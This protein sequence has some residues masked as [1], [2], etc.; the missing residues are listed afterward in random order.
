MATII[1]LLFYT[2]FLSLI[3]QLI[4]LPFLLIYVKDKLLD[5]GWAFGRLITWLTVSLLIWFPANLGL[6]INTTYVVYV[7]LASL[8][9]MSINL[10]Y[11]H[12]D[13]LRSQLKLIK[14]HLLI[15]ELLFL[16]GFIFLALFRSVKADILD[17]EKFMDA[18]F[19]AS[20]LRAH[21]L[22]APDMWLAGKSINYYSFGH[23]MGSI[24]TRYWLQ[25]IEY[26]YNLLLAFIM[27]LTMT[28]AYSLVIN[29]ARLTK[30][31]SNQTGLI[32]GGIVGSILL[33][34]GG[35]THTI[36][37]F[38]SNLS[39][40]NYWYA[41]AT[42]FIDR[43]IHEFPAYSFVVSDIH[44]H[45]WDLPV[46]LLFIVVVYVWI[47]SLLS[48][49]HPKFPAS[50][51]WLDKLKIYLLPNKQLNYL[52]LAISMGVLLGV[53]LMTN[54]W[55]MAIYGLLIAIVGLVILI[56][57]PAQFFRL[58]LSALLVIIFLVLASSGWWMHFESIS[59]GVAKAYEHSPLWQLAVLWTGHVWLSLLALLT[60][61]GA[62]LGIRF[63]KTEQRANFYYMLAIVITAWIL[64]ILPELIYV[65][66][67][68]TGHPRANTMF[69]LTYQAFI[70]M[71]L[72]GAWVVATLTQFKNT[73]ILL[74]LPA[75]TSV[76]VI[77]CLLSL[78]S[79][80]G[81]RD[82]FGFHQ[83]TSLDGL[84]WFR[85]EAPNDYAALQWLR[86]YVSGQPT[87]LEAV[88]ESYTTFDRFSAFSGLPTV[89]GWRVHE[90]LW[91]GGFDI[92]GKRTTE[93]Q[94]MYEQPLSLESQRLY[95]QYKVQYIIIGQ[96][97]HEAYRVSSDI[98]SL[99]EKVFS[100]GDV[101]I[102]KREPRQ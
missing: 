30:K 31:V 78:F 87:I 79:Y 53:M 3:L 71:S 48:T 91:R 97:E 64:L 85:H 47:K 19:M 70:L 75:I 6:P 74:R 29:L 67:I 11:H 36:W 24:M 25:T 1:P 72:A 2:W 98:N 20:Y 13:T 39:W 92:P 56:W 84:E 4:A 73:H 63:T 26:S 82:Y 28:Q 41:S 21:R 37:Y 49:T 83:P 12:W 61:V 54:A 62:L 22:P 45:V 80:F 7:I 60:A 50:T 5:S 16:T 86:H 52:F 68:Y 89:L 40:Q 81:Y 66:D 93:V 35:N 77:T 9:V 27:G 99:G 18:G 15:E 34:I 96:K 55:D 69:K 46:V 33:S 57:Y 59:D 42:R 90:W 101:S 43:T 100:Q 95:D 17:L 44:G 10:T 88:G 58:C 23:Y 8:S 94:Q 102:I 14:K 76:L 32:L 65:K 38:L 51:S